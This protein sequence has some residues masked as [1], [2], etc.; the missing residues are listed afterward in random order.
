[1]SREKCTPHKIFSPFLKIT[2]GSGTYQPSI[3]RTDGQKCSL[4]LSKGKMLLRPN[5]NFRSGSPVLFLLTIQLGCIAGW[6]TTH[7]DAIHLVAERPQ[8]SSGPALQV[9]TTGVQ[10]RQ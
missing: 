7:S 10:S 5:E 2:C 1:M 9:E 4:Y 3:A 6:I 8:R